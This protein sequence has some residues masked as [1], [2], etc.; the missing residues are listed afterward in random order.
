[1]AGTQV[2]AMQRTKKYRFSWRDGNRVDLL[3]DGSTFFPAM[4]DAIDRARR[5]VLL[6]SY[7]IESGSVADRFIQALQAC[8]RR[9]VPAYLLLDDFGALG[10]SNADR[11]R[12][13]EAGV[14]L[15]YYNPLRYGRFKHNLFR[16]HRKLLAVDGELAFVGGMGIT[17]HFDPP[18]GD[19]RLPWHETMLQIRGPVVADWEQAFRQT[20][21]LWSRAPLP[22]TDKREPPTQRLGVPGR[23]VTSAGPNRQEIQRSLV[24][25]ARNARRRIWIATAYF[26]PSRKLRRL[27]RRAARKGLDV[28]LLVPGSQTD[29]PAIRQAGRRFYA[30]LLRNGVRIYEYQPRFL[31][32]K[33]LLCDDWVSI[34]SSNLDRWNFRWNL[35]ANQEV[36]DSELAGQVA[37]FF[38]TDFA[39]SVEYTSEAWHR[40]SL[41]KRVAEWFWGTVDLWMNRISEP[42][43]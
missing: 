19:S 14:Q 37:H 41:W 25:R 39:Q 18:S 40:R 38:A 1:M 17:D 8:A 43:R 5:R 29:H 10:L 12:L 16:N 33:V 28:R 34:G 9:K 42:R 36:V 13:R 32:A 11:Q 35:E 6:E 23:V 31:H 20:W 15:T 3:V 7:L 26:I 27:L 22:T 4:L 21:N 24:G 30:R 2:E